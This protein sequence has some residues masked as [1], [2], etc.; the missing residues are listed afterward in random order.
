MVARERGGE[1][2]CNFFLLVRGVDP[3][4]LKQHILFILI[5]KVSDPGAL[6]NS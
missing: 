6:S 4:L 1:S 5:L 2:F 3:K